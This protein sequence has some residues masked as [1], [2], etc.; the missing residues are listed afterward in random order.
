MLNTH[1]T[2][3]TDDLGQGIHEALQALLQAA[4]VEERHGLHEPAKVPGLLAPCAW[5][6]REAG[7]ERV[8]KGE[9]RVAFEQDTSQPF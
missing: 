4:L 8:R 6:E 2:S 3:P 7:S 5:W 9:W 1:L